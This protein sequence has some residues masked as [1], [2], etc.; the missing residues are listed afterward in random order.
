MPTRRQNDIDL[1]R[2]QLGMLDDGPEKTQH[3]GVLVYGNEPRNFW[4]ATPILSDRG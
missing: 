2:R 1:I 4:G 3:T